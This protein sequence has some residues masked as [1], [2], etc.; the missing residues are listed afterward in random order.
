V[1]HLGLLK[2]EEMSMSIRR[3]MTVFAMAALLLACEKEEQS[4]TTDSNTPTNTNGSTTAN[5]GSSHNTGKNCLSCHKFSVGGS[6]YKKD[7]ASTYPGSVVKLTTQPNGA[8]TVVATLTTDNSGN[9]HTSS[10]I[11]FGT[12][13][14]VSASGTTGTKYMS[15]AITSG[16]CNACHGGATSKVWT[17]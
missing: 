9:I 2:I 14:Y 6:V 15:S 17:E 3:I 1:H 10:S 11:S 13:L 5:L 4:A 7:L 8:G 12:G 16:G